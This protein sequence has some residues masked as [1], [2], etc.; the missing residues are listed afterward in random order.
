MARYSIVFKQSVAKD[1]RPIPN[2]DV[3]RILDRID[4]LA[5][6]PRLAGAEKLSSDEKYRI[7]Q[8]NYRILYTIEDD[9]ITV[10][11]VKAWHRRDV[12]R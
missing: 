9:I 11:I 1:L 4:S 3:Q 5:D 2:K 7:R 12:Y 10:T 8:G 6:D